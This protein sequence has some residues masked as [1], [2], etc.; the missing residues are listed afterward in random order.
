MQLHPFDCEL[1]EAAID[2]ALLQLE[3][4]DAVAQ[5][6]AGT[7]GAL[8]DHDSVPGSG[9][10]LSGSKAGRPRPHDSNPTTRALRRAPRSEPTLSP[11]PLDDLVLDLLDGHWLGVDAEHA[12]RL[13]RR[14]AQPSRE[15][16]EVVGRVQSL[17]R[18]E[19]VVAVHEVVPLGDQVAQR[20]RLVAEGDAAVHA[21]G[22]LASSRVGGK[23]FVHLTPVAN[24]DR[25]PPVAR[26]LA[27]VLQEPAG[28]SHGSPALR[29]LGRTQRPLAGRRPG[30]YAR[31]P[32]PGTFSPAPPKTSSLF[33]LD[34]WRG[35]HPR[36]L[37]PWRCTTGRDCPGGPPGM[38]GGGAGLGHV[39][40][41]VP[42]PRPLPG[43]GSAPRG[44]PWA[45]RS[46]GPWRCA[47]A[48]SSART[49]RAAAT[50]LASASVTSA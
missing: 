16:G 25:D 49:W 4:G 13:A 14:G 29:V 24:P 26:E 45:S 5:Q 15:V 39:V 50:M 38:G 34:S 37:A 36:H 33:F 11:G 30:A 2:H 1:A 35:R 6:T 32:A 48:A 44:E 31:R 47:S 7:R 17:A 19:P 42:C 21:A 10:L 43:S 20:A 46:A 22:C 8:E 23:R 40:L 9:E 18:L 27:V 41:P 3:L 28:V 12:R